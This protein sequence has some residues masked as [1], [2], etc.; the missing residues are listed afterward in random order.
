MIIIA[1]AIFLTFSIIVGVVFSSHLDQDLE[2]KFLEKNP[3][4]AFSEKLGGKRTYSYEFNE[5]GISQKFIIKED[6]SGKTFEYYCDERYVTDRD[7]TVVTSMEDIENV[8]CVKNIE[9]IIAS[10][11]LHTL[12]EQEQIDLWEKCRFSNHA[13]ILERFP[14]ICILD[15]KSQYKQPVFFTTSQWE[16][17]I[18]LKNSIILDNDTKCIAPNEVVYYQVG[19]LKDTIPSAEEFLKMDCKD[20]THL[21]PEF[22]NVDV[23]DAWNTRMHECI[24]EQESLLLQTELEKWN[25]ISC[26][27]VLN[28]PEMEF[29]DNV[30]KRA[31]DIRWMQCLENEN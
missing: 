27:E 30:D 15:D 18:S 21:F 4:F 5:E 7:A 23:A 25:K 22:P 6:E 3:D 19:G 20:L 10:L 1:F 29:E 17:C 9:S 13:E 16:E 12:E 24:N 31:F 11:S 8:K 28:N 2:S 26:I 14:A